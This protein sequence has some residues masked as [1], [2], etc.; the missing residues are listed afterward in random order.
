M[1]ENVL[2]V[3]SPMLTSISSFCSAIAA[4]FSAYVAY[5]NRM[6]L[7]RY[8][9]SEKIEKKQRQ[10]YDK[11]KSVILERR[12]FVI[13]EFYD[14]CQIQAENL[15]ESLNNNVSI[16]LSMQQFLS[17]YSEQILYFR[18]NII[19]F[20]KAIDKELEQRLDCDL[21]T[22]QDRISKLSEDMF[23]EYDSEKPAPKYKIK[24]FYNK[25]NDLLR[26][27][28][29]EIIRTIISYEPRLDN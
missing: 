28:H 20:V 17:G 8:H 21:E 5:K 25:I 16:Q 12:I 19:S 13:D 15:L 18:K 9:Q 26:Q 27:Q 4:I 6:E 22:F 7:K 14:G 3:V 10:L 1:F 11:Y 24:F 2:E 23:S 29:I